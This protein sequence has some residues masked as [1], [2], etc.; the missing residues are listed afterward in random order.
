M[1]KD[2]FYEI[3]WRVTVLEAEMVTEL[4]IY[5]FGPDVT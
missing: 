3:N 1:S 4:R 5:N 2:D